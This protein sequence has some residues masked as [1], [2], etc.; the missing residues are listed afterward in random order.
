MY[1]YWLAKNVESGANGGVDI[2][3]SE[4]IKTYWAK[5]TQTKIAAKRYRLTLRC[6]GSRTLPF[7]YVCFFTYTL[8]N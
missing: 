3:N 6:I 5:R 1:K 4:Y 2:G 7:F 8:E